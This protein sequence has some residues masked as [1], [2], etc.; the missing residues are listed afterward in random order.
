MPCFYLLYVFL[1]QLSPVFVCLVSV[2]LPFSL[3][4]CHQNNKNAHKRK[5]DTNAT[6][7]EFSYFR[8][9]EKKRVLF[10][11]IFPKVDKKSLFVIPF[12]R[13]LQGLLTPS[14]FG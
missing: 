7:T 8:H 13:Q 12:S 9:F 2:K 3:P 11:I 1:I 14:M 6:F 4:Q 5:A 10:F